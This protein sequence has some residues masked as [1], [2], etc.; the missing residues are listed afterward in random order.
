ME[1]S[2]FPMSGIVI[3]ATLAKYYF[4]AASTNT[5][6]PDGLEIPTVTGQRNVLGISQ[7]AQSTQYGAAKYQPRIPGAR[8]FLYVDGNSVN[9][10][11]GDLIGPK[12]NGRGI[13]MVQNATVT[14][15]EGAGVNA[16]IT[17]TAKEK[18]AG[19][20]QI[21]VQLKDPSGNNQ[22]ESIV[23]VGDG[24]VVN[25][26]TGAGGAITS[27][28]TTIKATIEGDASASEALTATLPGSGATVVTAQTLQLDGAG[29]VESTVC[30]ARQAASS[31]NKLILVEFI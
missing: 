24:F 4:V 26:A 25:L 13:K 30:V 1:R 10:A 18:G 14:S 31:D 20:N 8:S 3:D 16:K 29:D 11:P 22:T 21:T 19:G 7:E 23:Q 28:P 6:Y 9:I 2:I 17:L 27:T 15:T 5:T 12:S